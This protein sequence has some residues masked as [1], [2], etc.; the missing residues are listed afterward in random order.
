MAFSLNSPILIRVLDG[1]PNLPL[2]KTNLARHPVQRARGLPLHYAA[3]LPV[4]LLA[5]GAKVV[6][7]RAGVA[8]AVRLAVRVAQRRADV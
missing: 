2:A 6:D 4:E 5:V 7:L 3:V 8:P 1:L